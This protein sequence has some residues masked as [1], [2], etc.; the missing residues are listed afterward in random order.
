MSF[1][2]SFNDTCP[3][4]HK[5][6]M[7]AVFESHPSN[8]DLALQN[9]ECAECGPIKTKILSLKPGTLPAELTI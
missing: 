6:I 5:S 7:R 2:T 1:T 4:C 9:F 8:R 3:K